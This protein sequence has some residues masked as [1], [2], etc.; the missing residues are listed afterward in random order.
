MNIVK[1]FEQV[2]QEAKKVTWPEKKDLI[3]STSVVVVSV[4]IFSFVVMGLDYGIHSFI[5]FLV[6]FGK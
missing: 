2:K 6:N 3:A 1:F 5:S 4:M